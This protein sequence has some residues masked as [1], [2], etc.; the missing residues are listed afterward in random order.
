MKRFYSDVTTTTAPGGF[1]IFLDGK[2]VKTPARVS[3][4]LPSLAL[5]EA[6]GDEWRAQ[7]D[8]IAP[9]AMLLT[10]LANTA[11][12]RVGP[13]RADVIGELVEYGGHDLLC[14]RALEPD[15]LFL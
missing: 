2:P 8:V 6:V 5:A 12:D 3:L 9:A 15:E 11:I 10:R 1:G 4:I 14:Y 13:G 7:G